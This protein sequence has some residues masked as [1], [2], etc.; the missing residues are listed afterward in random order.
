MVLLYGV[1]PT[2][3]KVKGWGFDSDG[4]T[5]EGFLPSHEKGWFQEGEVASPER[6]EI[7]MR[8]TITKVD[9]DT[10]THECLSFCVNGEEQE[11]PGPATTWTR[12]KAEK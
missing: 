10:H 9:P 3:G 1:D 7:E 11:A 5:Y 2:T 6:G 12:K 8:N 4:R